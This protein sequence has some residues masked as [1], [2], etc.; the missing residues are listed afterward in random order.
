MAD[1]ETTPLAQNTASTPLADAE[2][3]SHCLSSGL[4]VYLLNAFFLPQQF[5]VWLMFIFQKIR[6]KRLA[7]LGQ[8][9][10]SSNAS[11][12][13]TASSSSSSSSSKSSKSPASQGSTSRIASVGTTSHNSASAGTSN[14][15]RA[16]RV[17]ETS[18]KVWLWENEILR[19]EKKWGD[20]N[21]WEWE[22]NVIAFGHDYNVTF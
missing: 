17:E 7:K 19:S 13:A 4:H 9:V 22:E 8:S 20:Q 3:V 14:S 1:S 15:K 12:N 6:M 21:E 5:T 18:V 10:S 16:L 2:K 11:Q